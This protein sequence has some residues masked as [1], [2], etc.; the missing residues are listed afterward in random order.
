MRSISIQEKGQAVNIPT[1]SIL[2]SQQLMGLK[3]GAHPWQPA[4]LS[5]IL[6]LFTFRENIKEL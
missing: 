3:K 1:E 2:P 6:S 5:D 4:R